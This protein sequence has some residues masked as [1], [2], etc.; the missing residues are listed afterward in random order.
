MLKS[1][2][3]IFLLLPLNM[4]AIN[5]P[6]RMGLGLSGQLQN[7]IPALS[8]KVLQSRSFAMSGLFGISSDESEGGLGAG[9]KIYRIFFEEPQLNFYGGL[10]GA[11][12]K[13]K[14]GT[15]DH[16]GFQFDLTF[17]T[18][19]AFQGLNSIGFSL[20]FGLSMNKLDEFVVETVGKHYFS[21][22][23]HFYL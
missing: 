22:A 16:S 11:F 18:E 21:A 12:V 6:G 8:L 3:I 15:Q 9:L 17:G 2:F 23:V 10:L 5:Q 20:D 4:Y 13:E 1:L 19:F 14:K 7:D